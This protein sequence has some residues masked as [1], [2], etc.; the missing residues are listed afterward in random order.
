[1]TL[2]LPPVYPITDLTLAGASSHAVLTRALVQGGARWVQIREKQMG[3]Q[4]LALQVEA[5]AGSMPE[6]G[7]LLINDWAEMARDPSLDGVH[8]GQEDMAPE[9]ARR[10][11]PGKI[12]GISTHSLQQARAASKLPVD[13]IAIGPVFATATKSGNPPLGTAALSAVRDA[14]DMPLVAIG[15]ITLENVVQ[16]WSAGVESAAVI[17]DIM[18]SG[19]IAARTAAY[20]RLWSDL[21]A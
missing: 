7:R 13:Y 17:S 4:T 20:L 3:R 5:A 1:V 11:L 10:L 6:G 16:V 18:G 14:V 2:S 9:E 19:D 15:G 12:I 21:Y 8:L